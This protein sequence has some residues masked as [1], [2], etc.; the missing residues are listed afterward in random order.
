MTSRDYLY[1]IKNLWYLTGKLQER[2]IKL[3]AEKKDLIQKL[4]DK[5]KEL[6]RE[7]LKSK[8]MREDSK[9]P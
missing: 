8:P 4:E 2:I 5:T 1:S 3:E 6:Y 9:A 7:Q